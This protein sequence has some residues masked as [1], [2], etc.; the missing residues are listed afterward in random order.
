MQHCSINSLLLWIAYV[1][2]E[3]NLL[4]VYAA[5]ECSLCSNGALICCMLHHACKAAEN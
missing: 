4:V 1:A 5:M 3:N 2:I